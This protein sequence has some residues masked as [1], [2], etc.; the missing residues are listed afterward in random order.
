[1]GKKKRTATQSTLEGMSG[2]I[3]LI[4][5]GILLLVD[6]IDFWPWILLVIGLTS[7]PGSIA[8]EGF[9][10]GLQGL[11]WMGGLAILFYTH[12]IWPGILILIGLSTMAAALVRPGGGSGGG[13]EG[14]KQKRDHDPDLDE[15]YA[16]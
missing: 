14:D 6:S 11:I 16:G 12:T 13:P 2:G 5:L 9:W 1:M 8:K 4:G 7:V 10:A 15:E 3:F